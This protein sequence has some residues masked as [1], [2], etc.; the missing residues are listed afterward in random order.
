MST[1]RF[2]VILAGNYL[3]TLVAA[4]ELAQAGKRVC[5]VNPLPGWG[6][7]F[8]KLTVGGLAFD[9][10][11][12]SHEF[13][14]F[15]AAEHAIDPLSYDSRR[16]SDVGRFLGLIEQFTRSQQE[17]VR[18][19]E[20][21][22]VYGGGLHRDIVMG[23]QFDVLRHPVLAGRIREEQEYL[24]AAS[25][26][27][28]HPRHKK[29]SPLFVERSYYDVSVLNHGATL[30][31]ALFE[32]FFF[33]MSAVSTTRL[34]ALY[35]RIAW[36]PLYYPETL[37]S[38]FGT[39]PQQL[40]ETYFCYPRAGYVGAFAEALVRRMEST[41][42]TI[43]RDPIAA[44][45]DNP[46]HRTLILK[47]GRRLEAPK[48]GWSLAHDPLVTAATGGAPNPF[49]RWS[50]GLI[51]TTIA[52]EHLQKSFSVLYAP[53]DNILFY[54][55][56]NQS[57]SAGLDEDQVRVVIEINPDYAAAQGCITETQ[58]TTRL[59]TDLCTLGIVADPAQVRI[60]GARTLKNVL[61]LPS[62][63]NWR[64]LE[65]ER[66]IL[67]ERYPRVVFTRNVE[68]FFTDTLNDQVIKGLKLGEQFKSG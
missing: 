17:M 13:T 40:Q 61:L 7:H 16:R 56:S 20:A 5:V 18:M 42:V 10:G 64:L 28:L 60:V 38:Q 24:A 2:D 35:H 25:P 59:Q 22:T 9:P 34:L 55:A 11:A 15:N 46:E 52:R 37:R 63:E 51:F 54:R 26:Q 44:L 31:A 67:L 50:A 21:Q 66:D 4:G 36:L 19:K 45:E 43:I 68:A 1:D 6:G 12:V 32:P 53:D 65:Q 57:H 8:T 23:N 14:A 33:K 48:L 3:T 30:H 47:D 41:G 62:R 29:T 58:V 49:E 27:E 39:A